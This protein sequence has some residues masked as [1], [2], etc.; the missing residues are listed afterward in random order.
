MKYNTHIEED[1]LDLKRITVYIK[2]YFKMILFITFITTSLTGV[3]VYFLQSLYSSSVILSFSNQ[4]MSKLSSIIPEELSSLTKKK[5]ELETIKLTIKTRKFINSVIKD[6]KLEEQY[7]IQKPITFLPDNIAFPPEHIKFIEE[8]LKKEELYSFK[9][10]E[11]TLN[12]N[13][14]D[15][16][17]YDKF[18]KIE[19]VNDKQYILYI[20]EINYEKVHS[21]HKLIKNKEFSIK[22]IKSGETQYKKYLIKST[23]KIYLADK[24]LENLTVTILSDNV[25][26]ITYNNTVPQKAKELVD[27]IAKKFISYTLE[28][29]TNEISQTLL[30]LNNQIS[31]IKANLENDGDTL[32]K[33]QQQSNAFMP[34]ESSRL[35]MKEITLKEEKLNIL[36]SQLIEINHF[37]SS[38]EH[39]EFNTISLFNSGID[40]HSIQPL[41]DF[42]RK[43]SL[44]LNEMTLQSNNIEKPI[45][46][47]PQLI[48]LIN[49]FNEKKKLLADLE[50]N[51]TLG[52]PQVIQTQMDIEVQR[53]EINAYILTHIQ[54][55]TLNKSETKRKIIANIDMTQK[56]LYNNIRLLKKDI[57]NKRISLQSLPEK[58]LATQELKHKFTLSENIYTF[59]LEKKMEFEIAKASTIVNTQIIENARESWIPIKPNKKLILLV[60]VILGMILGVIFTWIRVLLDSKIRDAS[61]VEELSNIPLYGILPPKKHERF[62]QEA[63][64]N[65]RTNLHFVLPNTKQCVTVLISSTVASEGKTTVVASLAEIISQTNQKVLLIDLDLRKPRL[66]QELQR[67]N[68]QGISNYLVENTDI[69][70]LIQPV[71]DNL[72]FI[73]AGPVPPNPSELLMSEKFHSLINELMEQYDYILF[74]TAPIGSVIDA[75]LILEHADIT[76]LVIKAD[77]SEKIYLE[78]FHKLSKDK[79]IET[80]GIILNQVKLKN[81]K[82]YDYG[83]GYGY[84]YGQK[85]LS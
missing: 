25:L 43:E 1:D 76:L 80:S 27:A 12:I 2:R 77:Y 40:I 7:F 66:Y 35:I 52:H 39:N 54:K 15:S 82:K 45:S 17:L 20:K 32:K 75:S 10:L 23:K 64:R 55:L 18:F 65:I 41:I 31:D 29:K 63:L 57:K 48:H 3:Y 24:I 61:T 22:V 5:S 62:F 33:Y 21:Y 78:H 70:N 30:F 13:N 51:F 58:A 79:G 81:Q 44:E 8:R 19:P 72:D 11:V 59:L 16:N 69:K 85:Q 56:S 26:K 6:L 9:N 46:S 36:Q 84:G 47:N 60:G 73:A 42:F 67:S 49:Q 37:K 50:F 38:L 4:K 74:D 34:L 68:R 71:H 28:K 83:Y 53:D 14:L